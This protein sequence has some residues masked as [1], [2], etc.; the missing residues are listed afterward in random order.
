MRCDDVTREMTHSTGSIDP[1]QLA[2]HLADCPTC[3]RWSRQAEQLGRIWEAT[4]PDPTP[5]STLDQLWLNASARIEAGTPE[6]VVLSL[7]RR[8]GWV[9][10]TVAFAAAASLLLAAGLA[11]QASHHPENPPLIAQAT[12]ISPVTIPVFEAE[13]DQSLV[14]SIPD[15]QSGAKPSVT[16]VRQTWP[17]ESSTIPPTSVVDAMNQAEAMSA[18]NVASGFE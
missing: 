2:S 10:F 7:P 9:R 15:Q 5:P 18:I 13:V 14:V 12:Q 1:A 4:Q 16:V 17:E 6:P 8:P 3:A 11:W